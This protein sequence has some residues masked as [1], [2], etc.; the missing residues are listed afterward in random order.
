MSIAPTAVESERRLQ[1][2]EQRM[3]HIAAN[4]VQTK[5]DIIELAKASTQHGEELLRLATVLVDLTAALTKALD[6][7]EQQEKRLLDSIAAL[8]RRTGL[9]RR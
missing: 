6:A 8:E 5:T 7:S 3:S 9:W 4:V 2:V 1:A